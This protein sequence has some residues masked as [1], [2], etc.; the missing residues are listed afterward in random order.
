M[1][2]MS[3]ECDSSEIHGCAQNDMAFTPRPLHTSFSVSSLG[4]SAIVV[5][6]AI[7]LYQP[8]LYKTS[9]HHR[10]ITKEH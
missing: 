5:A 9:S 4:I 7:R 6:F 2:G 3:A 10:W 8:L 1:S